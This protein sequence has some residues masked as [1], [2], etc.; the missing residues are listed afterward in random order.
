MKALADLVF[1]AGMLKKM[2]RTGY[3][4]LGSGSESI[5]E[6]SFRAALIGYW[7]ALIDGEADAGRVALMML[8]HDLA[9]ARTGDLNY[10]NKRYCQADEAKAI[11]H[12]TRNLPDDLSGKIHELVDEFNACQTAEARIAHDADQLDF[13]VEL[14]EQ[15]DL[16]N[17]NAERW[18][19]YAQKRL[20]TDVG[21]SL[22][23]AVLE[24]KWTDWWFEK[25]EE[26]WVRNGDRNG[27]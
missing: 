12:A 11:D 18:L 25:R 13:M 19:Y 3:P 14:K 24:S 5:A 23:Q 1:E 22:A 27:E 20:Q 4:F 16:G 6:H 9:E 15:W 8:H 7:L 21:R 17:N 26:L 2:Q 10:M